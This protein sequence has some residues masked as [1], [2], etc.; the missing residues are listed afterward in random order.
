MNLKGKTDI[1]LRT[2]LFRVIRRELNRIA[3][4]WVLLFTT[5]FGP[6]S[7]FLLVSW[8]FSAAVVRDLPITVVDNDQTQLSR[9]IARMIDALPAANIVF[10][11]V[12]L[13]EARSRMTKGDVDAVIY[14]PD[15][16]EKSVQRGMQTELALY[17][18]NTNVVKG[19][20]LQSQL[21]TVLSTISGGVKLQTMV[22]K[23]IQPR[24]AI[25]KVQPIKPDIHLLFNPYG[26]YA[27]FLM[28]GL[29]PL[30]AVVFI[31]LGTSYAIG[32]EMKEGT[33]ADWIK[34]AGDSTTVA[35]IGKLIPYILLFFAGLMFMNILLIRVMGTPLNGSLAMVLFSEFLLILAYQAMAIVVLTVTI[36]LRLTLSLGSA[37]TMMAL[38]FS[39]LTF[40]AMG[41][42]LL[43]KFFSFV[44]PYTFWLKVFLSQSLRGEP[45]H[46]AIVPLLLL[47]PYILTGVLAFPLF[48]KR[49]TDERWQTKA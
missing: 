44:F 15:G 45:V 14:I 3:N 31:F 37:Y 23:G 21:V 7:V 4:S 36:N 22:K 42:P 38:T 13:E 16:L 1:L 11:S 39:G 10:K 35:L 5:I 25:L 6:A 32:I 34:T 48:K 40:P 29:L 2:S 12:S 28:M 19:G 41:M 26:N 47:L 9:K 17:L 24:D 30:L 33:G 20:V 43:A 8:M 18:N 49:L 27:Y 46:E